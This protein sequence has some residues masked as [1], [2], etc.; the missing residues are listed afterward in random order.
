MEPARELGE[1][2][3]ALKRI[4]LKPGIMIAISLASFFTY[5]D[6][7]NYSYISPTLKDTW[8]VTDAEIAGGASLTIVGYVA[9]AICITILADARGRKVGFIASILLLAAGSIL[10]AMSQN[11][12]QL[13]AFR[14]ITGAGIGSELVMS[15]VYIGEISPKSKRGKYTSFL[16]VL[17]W[18]GLTISGPIS[19]FLLQGN[20]GVEGWRAVLGI[21]GVVALFLLPFRLQMP[22]SPRWL[23]SK[24]MLGETNRVLQSVG[25]E[26]LQAVVADA[27][28]GRDFRFMRN[29]TVLLRIVFLGAV[30]FLA[31]IPIYSSLLLVVEYV[32]QG[33]TIFES[34]SINIL[35]GIGFAVGGI[36][37]IVMADKMERKYQVAI[38]CL[39][40]STGFILRGLLI[41]DF[42]GLVL[43]GFIAFFSNA[44]LVMALLAYTAENFP[45]RIRSSAAGIVEGSSRGL[46][47]IAPFIFVMLQP[48]GFIAVMTG[49]AAFSL[50][51]AGVMMA[52]GRRTRGESLEKLSYEAG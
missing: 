7:S 52:F 47:A 3:D 22:E 31:F 29:R 46:A 1:K 42:T 33:Y 50:A 12:A 9:G 18:T 44:W 38:A 49:V 19:L 25:V 43:A 14:F 34:I 20:V 24:G 10:A 28:P 36:M 32:N 2:I 16:A 17:G 39:A 26:P 6:V 30:W 41:H 40:M 13:M 27:G 51:G 21:A 4:P 15:S 37:A 11:M 8:G 35:G 5:Y 45:T 48:Y 23:L